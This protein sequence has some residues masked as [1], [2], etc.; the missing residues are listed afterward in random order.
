M[1]N[2]P[3][4]EPETQK[5]QNK[6]SIKSFIWETLKIIIISLII[7]LPIRYYVI[8]PFY[9][10]GASMEPNFYD[11]EYL[12][13]DELSY[14]FNLPERGD[15]VVFKYPKNPTDFFIKRII[16]LPNEKIEIQN[17]IIKIYNSENPNGFILD[18]SN[19]LPEENKMFDEVT[20]E[21]NEN[22]YFV[23]G[24][25]RMSSL[26]SR[27]FG[28]ITRSEIIGKTWLRG[29]PIDRFTVFKEIKY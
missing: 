20:F 19:Y 11:H 24:D 2:Q 1:E 28:P 22:E 18:E 8:Q 12:I 15:I 29:W 13:I 3:T 14:R 10:K 4:F 9:V 26:D 7:I 23:L 27:R 16:A 17:N 6:D 21:L 25:N 5:D